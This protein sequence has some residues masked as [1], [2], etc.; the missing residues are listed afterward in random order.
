MLGRPIVC[1]AASGVEFRGDDDATAAAANGLR[2]SGIFLPHLLPPAQCVRE[3]LLIAYTR[4]HFSALVTTEAAAAEAT[5]RAIGLP[6]LASVCAA[7]VPLAN[8]DLEPLPV[9]FPPTGPYEPSSL[10]AAYVDTA[11]AQLGTRAVPVALQ[12]CPPRETSVSM[13]A[14]TYFNS[15]W[16]QRIRQLASV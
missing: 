4:G 11:T 13:P 1:L 15:D 5:W 7:P 10:L 6:A 12:H 2:M 14:D 8:E 16:S 3:P 9:L